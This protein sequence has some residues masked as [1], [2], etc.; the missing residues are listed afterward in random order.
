MWLTAP[1]SLRI[2]VSSEENYLEKT[3]V[4]RK[5][6]ATGG[7]EKCRQKEKAVSHCADR[8]ALGVMQH[9]Q[10][11]QWLTNMHKIK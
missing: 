9:G 3:Q 5:M 11:G 1:E 8:N 10:D 7:K 2:T 6:S 4:A